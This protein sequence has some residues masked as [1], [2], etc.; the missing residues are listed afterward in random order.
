[1]LRALTSRAQT[2]SLPIVA[3]T[4]ARSLL[5]GL[6]VL[7]ATLLPLGCL[8]VCVLLLDRRGGCGL[9]KG[10][11]DHESICVGETAA[12]LAEVDGAVC[13]NCAFA[14]TDTRLVAVV[15]TEGASLL[16]KPFVGDT[17]TVVEPCC[18]SEAPFT[19]PALELAVL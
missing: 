6:A 7:L 5:L 3:G 12:S 14:V 4:F 11:E 15:G 1:M 10:P 19:D 16:M 2:P 17:G 13:C 18:S 8:C 9:A